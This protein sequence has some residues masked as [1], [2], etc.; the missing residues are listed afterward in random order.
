[1]DLDEVDR[2]LIAAL[3]EDA[4]RSLRELAELAGVSAP[5]VA[6]RVE[7]LEE[8][9]L[10]GPARREVDLTRLGVLVLVLAPPG[11]RR[12]LTEH[13]RVFRV[14]EAG[15][16]EVVALALLGDE[17]ELEDLEAAFPDARVRRLT[18]KVHEGTPPF[19]RRG[20][21]MR[22][23]ACGR[24]IEGDEGREVRLED[25]R[26]VACCP[27]CE[28]E[29]LAAGERAARTGGGQVGGPVS[30]A[31]EGVCD[32]CGAELDGDGGDV[33]VELGGRTYV[34]CCPNCREALEARYE[35]HE[36]AA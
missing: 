4:S 17:G 22:C 36:G 35:R 33:E 30:R 23:A 32:Q 34:V 29:L 19:T 25:R 12:A 16:D 5:T 21:R 11:D 26:V 3:L 2:R 1:M 8:L 28:R 9:G 27:T 18:G 20:V 13:D 14:Y 31:E 7:R 6:S 24:P 15:A 10:L